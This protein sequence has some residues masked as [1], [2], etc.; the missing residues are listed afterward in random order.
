MSHSTLN[1][2]S[3]GQHVQEMSVVL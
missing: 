1:D 3:K 2:K